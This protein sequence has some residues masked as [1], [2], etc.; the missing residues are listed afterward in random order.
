MAVTEKIGMNAD[1]GL[2]TDEV[3][4]IG[5][6]QASYSW[7]G[8]RRKTVNGILEVP[9]D[10]WIGKAGGIHLLFNPLE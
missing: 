1:P 6:R 4:G 9:Q 7:L 8:T 10:A 2:L 5:A 3:A